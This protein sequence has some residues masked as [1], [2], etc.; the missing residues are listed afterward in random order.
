MTTI[1]K[2]VNI[3]KNVLTE[4]KIKCDV[5]NTTDLMH[6]NM[7]DSIVAIEILVCIEETFDI[8]IADEELSL[9]LLKTPLFL[10]EFIDRKLSEK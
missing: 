5:I 6:S 10:S 4:N 2:T 9:E 3:I 7:I 8:V 1:E